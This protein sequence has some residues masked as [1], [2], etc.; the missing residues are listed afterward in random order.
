[1]MTASDIDS[2]KCVVNTGEAEEQEFEELNAAATSPKTISTC[3]TFESMATNGS[4][5]SHT[6]AGKEGA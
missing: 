3:N 2:A 1:M 5:D 6:H 4:D